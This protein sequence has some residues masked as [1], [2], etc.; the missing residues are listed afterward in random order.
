V[1]RARTVLAALAPFAL[2]G[3]AREVDRALGLVL[4]SELEPR[5]LVAEV[6]RAMAADGP[7]AVVHVVAWIVG[8]AL[9]WLALGLWRSLSEGDTWRQSLAREVLAFA[10]LYLRPALTLVAL[11]AVA[12]RPTYPYGFTLPVALTQDWAVGQDAAALAAVLA[13]RLPAPRLPA[14]GAGGVFFMSFLAYALLA[15]ASASRWEEHPG[16]EPKYLRQAVAIGHA[17]TFDAEGVNGPMEELRPKA[18]VETLPHAIVTLGRESWRL[19][20]VLVR[21]EGGRD[22]IRATRI[23]RQT[24][25]GKE[26]GVY[27]VLAPGPS[28]LLAPTLLLDRAINRARGD[29]GRVAVSVLAWNVLA[30]LLVAVLS[31]L[32]RDVTQRPGLAAAL[33]LGFGLLPP[34]LF[35]SFQFYPEMPGALVLAVAFRVLALKREGLRLHPWLFGWLLAVLP[36]LHQKFLP[37]WFV[38]VATALFV[39]WRHVRIGAP[40]D[41]GREPAAG[42]SRWWHG[43][44][45]LWSATMVRSGFA[46]RSQDGTAGTAGDPIIVQ[47][48]GVPAHGP[49]EQ[50]LYERAPEAPLA[51]AGSDTMRPI[52]GQGGA[53]GLRRALGLLLPQL[54]SLYLFAL[55]NFTITGSVRPDALFLAWGPGGVT[56]ARVGQGLLGLLLDARYGILPYVPVFLLAAAG[57]VLGGAKRFAVVLPAAA[58]YYLTV[59]SADNW[60]GAVC[61]LGRYFMPVAPLAVALVAMAVARVADRRGAVA[62]VLILVAW[63]ALFALALREDPLAAND[64][65]LLLSKSA[66]G[67]GNRYIPNLFIRH[68][69]DGAP[70]LGARI[71]AWLGVVALVAVWLRRVAPAPRAAA[72]GASA[73]AEAV[74]DVPRQTAERGASPLAALAGVTAIVLVLALALEYWPGARTAPCFDGTMAVDPSTVVF[75]TGAAVVRED[76]AVLGPGT[77]ELLARAAE[78]VTSLRVTVGGAGLLHAGGLRPLVLRRT[79]A[80][81]DLPFVR[82]H[83]VHGRAGRAAAFTRATMAVEG[84]AVLRFGE[85]LVTPP[86]AAPVAVGPVPA[87]DATSPMPGEE[88]EPGGAPLR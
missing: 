54:L 45:A 13:L 38:L 42:G 50:R 74:P 71:V 19:A 21:L 16:N 41:A 62:L 83:E 40:V 49:G 73:I 56:S 51:R 8:G 72:G 82:Y 65:G 59:A 87:S 75:V 17:L 57:P 5:G 14:P 25:R 10:P 6:A 70:G 18:L 34:L 7:A 30:A 53:P 76:E 60:A 39:G 29:A 44:T 28:V 22:A 47:T 86:A 32:A 58:V 12:W 31:L 9:V 84:Q 85:R 36:W 64:S 48:P 15:P 81:L 11:V 79:G 67:D 3:L 1:S 26:G 77:V 27:Y 35:Y 88:T 55:Y 66:F 37:V 43:A 33:A 20:G 2:H 46:W 4:R 80:L 68:W 61:N 24:I 23:T 63:S 69:S 52:H 78:P